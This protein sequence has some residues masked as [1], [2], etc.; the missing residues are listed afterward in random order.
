VSPK[1]RCRV[2]F[3]SCA[4]AIPG[5]SLEDRTGRFRPEPAAAVPRLVPAKPETLD[6]AGRERDLV[7]AAQ[8]GDGGAIRELYDSY[9]ERIWTLLLYS[10][11]DGQQAQDILQVVFLKVFRGLRGFRFESSLFTWIYRIARNEC[12]NQR[13][14]R[15]APDMPLESIF[16]RSEELD[17]RPPAG[18]PETRLESD[19][20]LRQA[21]LHLPMKM[22]EV[23]VL[24]YLEGQ[25]YEEM[26]R[27]LG[28]APGTVASR[29]NRALAELEVRLRPYRRFL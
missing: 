7:L 17:P 16:G 23:I 29:L 1:K 6:P 25:S 9:R 26:S 24:K 19:S 11:G 22:R 10:L 18:C 4:A 14:R 3:S 5:I 28:C 27:A 8:C 2:A 13:R 20:L 21:V 12:L 15:R